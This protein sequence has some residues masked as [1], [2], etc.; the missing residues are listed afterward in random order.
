MIITAD[1]KLF[2][3]F[4]P[5][6]VTGESREKSFPKCKRFNEKKVKDLIN[7]RGYEYAFL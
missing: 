5:V 1:F 2:C 4:I 3:K 6:G 7:K